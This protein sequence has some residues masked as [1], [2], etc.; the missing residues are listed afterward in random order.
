MS[1]TP[2]NVNV[3]HP[4]SGVV[5][6]SV[7]WWAK[8]IAKVTSFAASKLESTSPGF[9]SLA[10]LSVL[11]VRALAF[12]T[13]AESDKA[14]N[15][16]AELAHGCL[17]QKLRHQAAI[18][19]AKRALSLK[20]IP[21]LRNELS[22]WLEGVGAWSESAQV[23][24]ATGE[25]SSAAERAW[26]HRRLASLWWR[27]GNI[28]K[29][30]QSLAELARIDPDCT[31]P[32]ELLAALNISSPDVVSPERAVLAQLEA[33]R[34][35]QAKGSR[36]AAFEAELRAFEVDPSSVLAAEQLSASL[37]KLGRREAA[38]DI[39]RICARLT[40]D[41][42]L[43]Q[44]QVEKALARDEFDR[45][46][47]AGLD[48]LSDVETSLAASCQGLE[49]ALSPFGHP[50]KNF[51]GLLA[52][53]RLFGW[54]AARAEIAISE[55]L[56]PDKPRARLLLARMFASVMGEPKWAA[57]TLTRAFVAEPLSVDVQRMLEA[58]DAA[59]LDLLSTARV[60]VIRLSPPAEVRQKIARELLEERSQ[61]DSIVCLLNWARDTVGGDGGPALGLRAA[62]VRAEWQR[63]LRA[64]RESGPQTELPVLQSLAHALALD[65]EGLEAERDLL[66]RW[67]ALAPD[68][69]VAAERLSELVYV[70]GLRSASEGV[71]YGWGETFDELARSG[72]EWATLSLAGFWLQ[73]GNLAAAID[74]IRRQLDQKDPPSQ[75]LL[76]WAVTLA[77]RGGDQRLFADA[78]MFMAKGAD[79]AVAATLLAIAAEAYLEIGQP[80]ATRRAIDLGL[81]LSPNSARL[82]GVDVRA[83]QGA[84]PNVL[85]TTLERAL[86]VIPPRAE[87]AFQLAEAHHE[88]GNIELAIAWAHRASSL[89]PASA[90]YR[91][92]CARTALAA[93]DPARISEWLLRCVEIPTPVASWLT[94]ATE[95]LEA[96]VQLDAPR[97]AEVARQMVRAIGV[98]EIRWREALLKAADAVL[99]TRLA[100][101]ILERAVA[102]DFETRTA[103]EAIVR[104]RLLLGDFESAYDA[105]LRALRSGVKSE[106]IAQ[107]VP[108]LFDAPVQQVPETELVAAELSFEVLRRR[109]DPVSTNRAMRRL[110]KVAYN[111]ARDESSALQLWFDLL[112]QSQ[113]E[114][115]D[116]VL[117]DIVPTL[118]HRLAATRLL[119]FQARAPEPARR[120]EIAA[121]SAYVSAQ[122][123]DAEAYRSSIE[124]ALQIDPS[125]MLAL[126]I[127]ESGPELDDHL[128]WLDS[129]Y[130]KA[131]GGILGQHGQRALHYRAAKVFEGKRD[132]ARAV[133]HARA[134]FQ[135]V[136]S[137]GCAL[138]LLVG[139]SSQLGDSKE[140]IHA[141]VDVATRRG[142]GN[143]TVTWLCW[144]VD[145]LEQYGSPAGARLGLLLHAIEMQPDVQA[146]N[147][148]TALIHEQLQVAPAESEAASRR[149]A[150]VLSGQ[151]RAAEGPS[152]ARLAIVTAQVAESVSDAE[153]CARAL[154]AAY[155]CDASMDE[156]A[157]LDHLINWLGPDTRLAG[158]L[159]NTILGDLD[160]PYV[161]VGVDAL[162]ALGSLQLAA[163]DAQTLQRLFGLAER[164]GH[165]AMLADWLS[166][167]LGHVTHSS[168]GA[169]SV[170]E[171]LVELRLKQN[172]LADAL[173]LL[174][175]IAA[176]NS[177]TELANES[178]RQGIELIKLQRGLD[179]AQHW[180]ETVRGTLLPVQA[181]TVELDLARQTG[182]TFLIVQ[183]LCHR[184]FS[185]PNEPEEGSAQ[186][187]EAIQLA[188]GA[189]LI[190]QAIE[191]ARAAVSWNPANA[192][193][194]LDL[195]LLLHRSRD[196]ENGDPAEEII[197][198]LRQIPE[199]PAA[200][201]EELRTYLLAEALDSAY[202]SGAGTDELVRAHG[203]VG[204][205][206]L[207]A[208]GLAER[209]ALAGENEAA[210][211]FFEQA[212]AGD[213]RH[214]RTLSAVA[215]EAARLAI[216]LGRFAVA[217]QW[218]Q[219]AA[220][221][222][223][224]TAS[225][226]H[227][228][229]EVEQ[230]LG[231]H[232]EDE[233]ASSSAEPSPQ[234]VVLESAIAT[235]PVERGDIDDPI[236]D[237]VRIPL[238]RRRTERLG[239]S[240]RPI[241]GETAAIAASDRDPSSLDEALQWAQ[242]LVRQAS[243]SYQTL[244]LLRKWMRQW[245]GSTALMEH[246]REA[247]LVEH[248]I[249]L[250]RA[251]E[252]ARG[253]L[254]GHG[255][256]IMAPELSC[257]PVV[258]EAVSALLSKDIAS[259]AGEAIATLWDG[260]EHLVQRE[261]L[262]YGVTGLDRVVSNSSNPLWL[263]AL[264]LAP[265][266]GAIRVPL[267]HRR[268]SEPLRSTVALSNPTAVVLQGELPKAEADLAGV[269]GES[270]W[271]THSEYSVLMSAPANRVKTILLALQLA[272]GP[273]RRH[274]LTNMTESLKLAEKLW[275]CI[276][277]ASQRLLRELC[278]SDFDYEQARDLAHYSRR[279]A[280]LYSTGDLHW[281]LSQLSVE[282]GEDM[283]SVAGNPAVVDSYPKV[284][285]LLRLATSAE[286]AAIR[287]QPSRG[288]ER[289]LDVPQR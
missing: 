38:E 178:V 29:S 137:Q 122:L 226:T 212:A 157:S 276:P 270:L 135:A 151:L 64:A 140:L 240:L 83:H 165:Q 106:I 148:A 204:G 22:E 86:G 7:S 216:E 82:V 45:A 194:S 37:S 190:T 261:L 130:E 238:V 16:W 207:I 85:A 187:R 145:I 198:L 156:F 96:L 79:S 253:A 9:S 120:S 97:A 239:A 171:L 71:P 274:P 114:V 49:Y 275:E 245:P 109:S 234:G 31:E 77:R 195:A 220:A 218:L 76:G 162:K 176:G 269:V 43:H 113:I 74:C 34:R 84:V 287:W 177:R 158:E 69:S 60:D 118:G 228:L 117:E 75:R 286:Y 90:R 249:P 73:Q 44:L 62:E 103:L 36:L 17:F 279:R 210:L 147:K 152:G 202:G 57:L 283:L 189:G 203:R 67:L 3:Q 56:G 280:G 141:I 265:R 142:S 20:D 104:R 173:A 61:D 129:V 169:V 237:S 224:R 134:A 223:E 101:D 93:H 289:R 92:L 72:D 13:Q 250:S 63:Q 1:L 66:I 170:L 46:L 246:V 53:S 188:E 175:S 24:L 263:I 206:P 50:P 112:Q 155:R 153:L 139:L 100:V 27:A 277:S 54:L 55:R 127:A 248:D 39:W 123:N 2:E 58:A 264:E 258:P 41:K 5:N 6:A 252:H 268:S 182:D 231:A 179:E 230:H 209:L 42:N 200:E 254:L 161:N 213:L 243:P 110:A 35:Y 242:Y 132:Y 166:T 174:E 217:E 232:Q 260:G 11:R 281:S 191:C 236:E 8:P 193:A 192:A 201:D 4:D 52:K 107:W 149:L 255:E 136:P 256:R 105:A 222:P 47:G 244:S 273:P 159:L 163:G 180:F 172:Q 51:D 259:T 70:Q 160:Q 219:T 288:S 15:C 272:F 121:A 26:W 168:A 33:A 19:Y 146:V 25:P 80:Q 186:L 131:E 115:L 23:L 284:V 211:T 267:F 81:V 99:D 40:E 102:A 167:Q 229:E 65:P 111:Y 208:L 181:A 266:L 271:L 225:A 119:E 12:E 91:D 285:D 233:M 78:L 32:L 205:R 48:A 138:R 184:A 227:L 247:A 154:R 128:P 164:L 108:K 185:N 150:E 10:E 214:F 68:S 215:I 221:D 278:Q 28:E 14:A 124:L 98:A 116:I 282:V 196:H 143:E 199:F 30:A 59:E 88:L 133:A 21:A 94:T 235:P 257:Q 125:N 87:F 197:G 241:E 183:A 95:L 126:S 18:T 262:D 251:V 89:K 144:V